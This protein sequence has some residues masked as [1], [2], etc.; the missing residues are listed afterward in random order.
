M[1]AIS[2]HFILKFIDFKHNPI[3]LY[4]PAIIFSALPFLFEKFTTVGICSTVFVS[5][6]NVLFSSKIGL[7]VYWLYY[8]G[9]LAIVSYLF[10]KNYKT[11]TNSIMRKISIFLFLG[12]LVAT[13]PPIIFIVIFPVFKIS[14]PSIYC[15]FALLFSAL[16]FVAAYLDNKYLSQIVKKK[17]L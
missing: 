10:W 5:V 3:I 6:K 8:F 2:L 12:I 1:P 14:F 9:Y 11:D 17:K 13:L 7:A 15:D 4:I 16:A